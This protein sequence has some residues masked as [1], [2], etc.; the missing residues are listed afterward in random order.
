MLHLLLSVSLKILLLYNKKDKWFILSFYSCYICKL[1]ISATP[2]GTKTFIVPQT[3]DCSIRKPSGSKWRNVTPS[4][5]ILFFPL[6]SDGTA[7]SLSHGVSVTGTVEQTGAGGGFIGTKGDW[8]VGHRDWLWNFNFI[9][10]DLGRSCM[11][12]AAIYSA[13]TYYNHY[14]GQI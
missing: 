12:S 9:W 5:K 11:C 3:R 4:F 10:A 13:L 7:C 8:Q 1:G 14:S 6:L 2:C